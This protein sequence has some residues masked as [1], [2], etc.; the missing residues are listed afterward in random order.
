MNSKDNKPEDGKFDATHYLNVETSG[1]VWKMLHTV[2]V[3]NPDNNDQQIKFDSLDEMARYIFKLKQ[4]NEQLRLERDFYKC[5]GET[6]QDLNTKL[7][8]Q[9]LNDLKTFSNE[10]NK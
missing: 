4:E 7:W 3:N 1:S 5:R 2:S 9:F 6:D 8:I 10:P